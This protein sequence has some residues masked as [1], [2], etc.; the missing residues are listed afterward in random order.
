MIPAGRIGGDLEIIDRRARRREGCQSV[1]L[2]VEGADCP[3]RLIP[4]LRT[5]PPGADSGG[6]LALARGRVVHVLGAEF[7]QRAISHAAIGV[8]L[9][10]TQE[11]GQDR[12]THHVELGRDRIDDS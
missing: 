4:S 1:G 11:V 6:D 2:G 3:A 9:G 7:E 10:R 12:R 8:A 5:C